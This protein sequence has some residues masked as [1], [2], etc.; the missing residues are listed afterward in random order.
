MST[1]LPYPVQA[2]VIT[3]LQSIF[4][5]KLYPEI[6]SEPQVVKCLFNF[7]LRKIN[8]SRIRHHQSYNNSTDPINDFDNLHV[9]F[10]CKFSYLHYPKDTT[11]LKDTGIIQDTNIITMATSGNKI[12]H[13]SE[14]CTTSIAAVKDALYVLNGKWKLPLI[15]ALQDGPKR[16]KDIQRALGEITPV[17]FPTS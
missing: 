9:Y 16:F 7:R 14:A 15:I 1:L 4:Y 5:G 11:I 8:I 12:K 17:Y 10:F 13:N 6:I 2:G 3:L